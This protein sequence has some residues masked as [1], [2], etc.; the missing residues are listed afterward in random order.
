MSQNAKE[1]L[2]SCLISLPNEVER[3]AKLA[4]K[5]GA[6]QQVFCPFLCDREPSLVSLN[7][8]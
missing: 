6:H 4:E 3:S 2:K 5:F 8:D 1:A 7:E